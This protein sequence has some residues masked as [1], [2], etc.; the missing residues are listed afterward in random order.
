SGK[1][2]VLS[3]LLRFYDPTSGAIRFD[4]RDL[5]AATQ[6]SLRA[7]LAVVFQ[8]NML[9]HASVRENIRL[10]RPEATDAEVEAAARAAEIHDAIVNQL[11]EGYDTV[12]GER[13]SQLSGGQRQRIALARA[14]IR[15]PSVLILDEV[16]S[17]LD[18]TTAAAVL[19]TLKSLARGR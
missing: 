9:F 2:T 4:G 8:D 16:T 1:S 14:L 6:E 5:R 15:D 10:G 7:Q 12:V 19:A 18:Q 17:A 3:L 11:P 13:G